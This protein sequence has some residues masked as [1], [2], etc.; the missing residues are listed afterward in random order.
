MYRCVHA[1][2]SVC[3][4]IYACLSVYTF[5]LQDSVEIQ[6][7]LGSDGW[8]LSVNVRNAASEYFLS[9]SEI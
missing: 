5:V 2:A 7:R 4:R 1:R 3:V 6:S 8:L 9:F